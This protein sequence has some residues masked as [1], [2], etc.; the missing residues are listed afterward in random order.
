MKRKSKAL[1]LA[2]EKFTAALC[3]YVEREGAVEDDTFLY[4][5]TLNTPLGPL[6]I[7]VYD[8]WIATCFVAAKTAHAF[9]RQFWPNDSNRFSGKWNFHFGHDVTS[10]D[11]EH[12]ICHFGFFLGKLIC[13]EPSDDERAAVEAEVSAFH[14]RRK[15]YRQAAKLEDAIIDAFHE[16]GLSS[17]HAAPKWED[18]ECFVVAGG[19]KFE[20]RELAGAGSFNG[21]R[22][23]ELNLTS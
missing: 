2:Q 10:L 1:K 6:A 12:C 4:D 14:K 21:W 11:P 19:R 13:Y 9:T 3:D 15:E 18:G 16:S 7:T 22:F 23:R 5:Y 17:E 8:T 20:A